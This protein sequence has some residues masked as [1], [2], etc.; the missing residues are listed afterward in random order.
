MATKT[1]IY[2]IGWYNAPQ[3]NSVSVYLDPE[4]DPPRVWTEGHVGTAATPFSVWH[5]RAVELPVGAEPCTVGEDLQRFL[6]GIEDLLLALVECYQG[7]EWD[8]SNHIGQWDDERQ[9]ELLEQIRDEA[10]QAHIAAYWA[11]GD[12]LIHTTPQEIAAHA[13]AAGG[14]RA[15]AERWAREAIPEAYLDV[16]DLEQAIEQAIEERRENG[17]SGS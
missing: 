12:W 2:D 14:A 15:L 1:I 3:Y 4:S 11:A 9:V 10:G 5:H 7:S 16:D 6:T 17:R 8:G 13:K